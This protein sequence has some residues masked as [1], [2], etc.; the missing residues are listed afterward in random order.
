MGILGRG[1]VPHATLGIPWRNGV[2]RSRGSRRNHRRR[3]QPNC[4]KCDGSWTHVR[5]TIGL[6]RSVHAEQQSSR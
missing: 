3:G 4:E 5:I 2:T 1:D 6:R